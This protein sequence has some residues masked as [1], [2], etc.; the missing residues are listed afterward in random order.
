M[1]VFILLT[2]HIF[3]KTLHM[4]KV[5]NIYINVNNEVWRNLNTNWRIWKIPENNFH[6]IIVP[7][8][9]C[10]KFLYDAYC[11]TVYTGTQVTGSILYI[12]HCYKYCYTVH[13]GTQVTSSILQ[14]LLYCIHRNIGIQ[15]IILLMISLQTL[16]YCIHRY[17]G[18]QFNI[19]LITQL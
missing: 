13:T 10:R 2:D 14:T 8:H 3:D 4:L 5:K 9:Q 16:L 1:K 7:V 6:A 11:H 18:Y 12:W 17:T 15:V 19:L